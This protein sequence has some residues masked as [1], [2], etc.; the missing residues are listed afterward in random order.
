MP[1]QPGLLGAYTNGEVGEGRGGEEGGVGR[2]EGWG[3]YGGGKESKGR[4][5]SETGCRSWVADE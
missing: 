4:G 3:E 2:G 1:L 5:G